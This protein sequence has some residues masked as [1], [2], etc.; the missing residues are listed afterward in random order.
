MGGLGLAPYLENEMN[1]DPTTELPPPNQGGME[2]AAPPPAAP[3]GAQADGGYLQEFDST[4]DIGD[5][6]KRWGNV[7]P[8]FTSVFQDDEADVGDELPS[9]PTDITATISTVTSSDDG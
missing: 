7:L 8:P 6:F 5:G 2:P 3:E 1:E 4:D 9:Q